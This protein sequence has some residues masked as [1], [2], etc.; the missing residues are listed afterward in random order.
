[1]SGP[2]KTGP[3]TRARSYLLILVAL[4]GAA[5]VAELT[6]TDPGLMAASPTRALGSLLGLALF[7]AL[8]GLGARSLSRPG[9]RVL[10]L[11]LAAVLAASSLVL[12]AIHLAAHVGGLRPASVA[13]LALLGLVLA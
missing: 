2:Q 8:A 6:V 10:R 11:G 13:L 1:M 3:A 7:L 4:L 12:V 9:G 5:D